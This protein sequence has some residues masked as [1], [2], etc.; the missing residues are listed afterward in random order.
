MAEASPPGDTARVSLRAVSNPRGA[1]PLAVALLA[2]ACSNGGGGSDP[3]QTS[4]APQGASANA[5]LTAV[6][7][8]DPWSALGELTGGYSAV[9]TALETD[10]SHGPD[11]PFDFALHPVRPLEPFSQSYSGT[12]EQRGDEIVFELGEGLVFARVEGTRLVEVVRVGAEGVTHFHDGFAVAPVGSGYLVSGESSWTFSD[13]HWSPGEVCHGRSSL[14]L[15][16]RADA[17]TGGERDLHFV[18][19]WPVSSA[20]DLDLMVQPANAG[21]RDLR[22]F[23]GRVWGGG[24]F[25]LRSSGTAG[26]AEDSRVVGWIHSLRETALPHHEEVIRC[27]NGAYGTW[28]VDVVNWSGDE[29]VD[30]EVEIFEG[31]TLGVNPSLERAIELLEQTVAPHSL[32]RMNWSHPPP[33][34]LG[35]EL[36][37]TLEGL[38]RKPAQRP[39]DP[40]SHS[41]LGFNKAA[42]LDVPY[43][44]FLANVGLD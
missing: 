38:A 15:E 13:G 26:A 35:I 23:L 41:A 37:F 6:N 33:P 43:D 7:G 8:A 25:V 12:I 29:P 34:P 27:A 11:V 19:R 40:I 14:I 21:D 5:L 28:E 42:A 22:A 9:V 44:E 32:T 3:G 2:L 1:R 30:F 39:L 16:D 24:C 17:P 20:A 4:L 31:P 10:C 18:L 36:D